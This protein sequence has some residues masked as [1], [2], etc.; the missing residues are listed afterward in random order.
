MQTVLGLSVT[1]TNVRTVLV[2]GSEADGVTLEHDAFDVFSGA[3]SPIRASEQVAEAVLSIAEADGHRLQTIG[4]TWSDTAD[5]EAALVLD[6]LA[7][8]GFHNVVPVRLSQAA[9]ALARSIGKV[10]GYRRTAVCVVEPDTTVLSLVD[11]VDG[12]VESLVDRSV[13]GDR[14]LLD[15]IASAFA[16]DGWRPEGLFMVGSVGGGLATWFADELGVPVFDP[17]EAELALAHG[18]ALASAHGV[19]DPWPDH[20][21]GFAAAHD[22]RRALRGPVV[23]LAGGALALVVSTAMAITPHVLPDRP[24]VSA[25]FTQVR[26]EVPA[27]VRAPAPPAAVV[28]TPAEAAPAEQAP[29]GPPV[30]EAAVEQAPAEQAPVEPSVAEAAPPVD[31]QPAEEPPAPEPVTQFRQ[32]TPAEADPVVLPPAQ[33][34]PQVPEAKPRLRDRILSRLGLGD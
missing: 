24:E 19:P 33:V 7:G 21:G 17:P 32:I 34:V 2:E 6:S 5:V 3:E 15:W 13:T 12:E 20:S 4:V 1:A 28:P 9:E 23:M 11:T 16:R 29:A 22:S 18:A 10:M 8:R 26:A 27:P 14:Q 25:D 30:E 31:V